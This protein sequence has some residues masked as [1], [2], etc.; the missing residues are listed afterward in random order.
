M[1]LDLLVIA[2]HPD[3]AEL[4]CSGAIL[5]YT[6]NGKRAG[7]VD[8]TQG[9]LGTRGT[10]EDR[11]KEAEEASRVLGLSVR[12]NLGLPDGFIESDKESVEKIISVL[13]KYKPDTVL[14]N[15]QFDRHP[16]HGN[17]G[18]LSSRACFL[19]GLSKIQTKI[20]NELQFPW[21]PLNVYH[22][23]QDRY[24]KPDFIL[25]ITEYWEEKVKAINAF[26]SQFF[27]PESNEPS[28]YIS[29]PEFMKFIEARA[30][31]FGHNIGVMYGEGYTADRG[32]YLGVKNLSQLL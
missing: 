25:D 17:A 24:I 1:K 2:A 4:C 12:E 19:S 20:G 7:I 14:I 6:R 16:D 8:L 9:E 31:E 21:R 10:I 30:L 27:N 29:S 18:S 28:T 32:R 5:S 13:R 3:D 11:F 26:K 15:A 23:I 22:F